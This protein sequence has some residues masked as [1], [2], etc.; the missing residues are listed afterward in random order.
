MAEGEI[1]REP[2]AGTE[3]VA[4]LAKEF[5]VEAQLVQASLIGW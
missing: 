2:S 4:E 3:V 5:G 1:G